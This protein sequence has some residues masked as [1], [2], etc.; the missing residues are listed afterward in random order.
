MRSKP[1]EN[2]PAERQ[3]EGNVAKQPAI[4]ELL[5][6]AEVLICAGPG[7]VGKTTT[8]A[9]LGIAAARRGRRTV[10]VTIDPAR[11]LADSLGLPA[12]SHE[13]RLVEEPWG[14]R[15]AGGTLSVMQLDPK[16]TFDELVARHTPSEALRQRIFGNRLYAQL[17]THLAG[18]HEY[19]AL[20]SLTALRQDDRFD[21]V[22]L[23][24]P[25]S[26]NAI[27]FLTA[28]ERVSR[29]LDGSVMQWLVASSAGRAR[30]LLTSGLSRVLSVMGKIT[31]GAL[32]E[33]MGRLIADLDGVLGNFGERA[34]AVSRALRS[35]EVH[36][37]VVASPTPE[38]IAEGLR[39]ARY[40]SREAM[41][42]S[43]FVANRVE[44]P[45]PE[46]DEESVRRTLSAEASLSPEAVRSLARATL[47]ERDRVAALAA[48]QAGGLS[49]LQRALTALQP[50]C[51][52]LVTAPDLGE[53]LAALAGLCRLAEAL[54][55]PAA[56]ASG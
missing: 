7:G 20:E 10:C 38:A 27:D 44:P 19:M 1:I 45:P 49:E 3:R 50:P 5:D 16:H 39:L 11:R 8:A 21:L 34:R 56:S 47:A 29:A 55:S 53:E 17:S 41:Q 25:P 18:V 13:A 35:P 52:V 42:V 40:L 48:Q 12:L 15:A 31:G 32:L 9:A 54:V 26:R 28:P 36:F 24:T 22:V 33:Q 4:V 51:R 23:D 30:G 37:A 6:R 14:S 46:V 43:A 2:V